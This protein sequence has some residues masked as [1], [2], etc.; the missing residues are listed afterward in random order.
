MKIL[1]IG[2]GGREHCIAWKLSQNP[3]VKEIYIAPGNGGTREVGTNVNISYNDLVAL[4]EFAREKKIDYTIV[5]PEAPL[6]SGI[7]DEFEKYGLKIFGPSQRAAI[8]EGSKVFSKKFM[9]KYDIPTADFEVA[10]GLDKAK[11]LIDKER[12]KF[13]YVIKADGLA[14]GKGS[15]IVEDKNQAYK[16]IQ[17]IM[18]KREFGDAGKKVVFE[19][20]MEGK[21]T[22]FM[23]FSDGRRAF[24]LVTSQD[25]KRLKN[26]DKGP[27]TGGMGSF[28]PSP[29]A[30]YNFVTSINNR[31]ITPAIYG[32]AQESRI[33]KGILYAGLMVTKDGPKVLEFNCR[34]GDPEIQSVFLRLQTDLLTIVDGVINN[35]IR[36]VDIDWSLDVAAC[37]VLAS[38]GYP[39]KYETGKKIN[40]LKR[41]QSIKEIQ[42]FHAGTKYENGKYYTKEGRVLNVCASAPSLKTA[43]DKI[44]SAISFISFENMFFRTDIGLERKE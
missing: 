8:I 29:L 39:L 11:E 42:I 37:V 1:V 22:S 14:G 38:G 34:L 35:N 16:A 4:S 10:N 19:E 13:P 28:S 7:V 33:F 9:K 41:A 21:E 3:D 5:G 36:N 18:I 26:D 40:G 25:Y 20:F 27:N 6:V 17:R 12:F 43:L 15:I 44:Y 2:S 32:M 23:V 30:E 24:P 31:V